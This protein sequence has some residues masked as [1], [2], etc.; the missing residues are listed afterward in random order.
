MG[1]ETDVLPVS[2]DHRSGIPIYVRNACYWFRLEIIEQIFPAVAT[3]YGNEQKGEPNDYEPTP[4]EYYL[5]LFKKFRVQS[6]ENSLQQSSGTIG[7]SLLPEDIPPLPETGPTRMSIGYPSCFRII[8]PLE[9]IVY[10][11][12]SYDMA[13]KL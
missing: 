1:Y 12:S 10:F 6:G 3:P 2:V 11:L 5:Y 4:D 7:L 9:P 13:Q 8:P